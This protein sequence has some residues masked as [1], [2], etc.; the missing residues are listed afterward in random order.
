MVLLPER[1]KIERVATEKEREY[2]PERYRR[3][4]QTEKSPLLRRKSLFVRKGKKEN[5]T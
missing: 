5:L 1:G 4:L 2:N 3:R